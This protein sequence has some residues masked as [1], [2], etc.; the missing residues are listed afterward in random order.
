MILEA[1]FAIVSWSQK[2]YVC[3]IVGDRKTEKHNNV[4]V[5]FKRKL[6]HIDKVQALPVLSHCDPITIKMVRHFHQIKFDIQ[7][8]TVRNTMHHSIN[9]TVRLIINSNMGA[10]ISNV[11]AL[12]TSYSLSCG[13]CNIV[14]KR[15]YLTESGSRIQ[16]M[17]EEGS[18]VH[19]SLDILGPLE[20]V[21]YINARKKVKS[22]V[23]AVCC[24]F[25]GELQFECIDSMT[26]EAI[27][28]GLKLLM[29]R[30]D[31]VIRYVYTDHFS[32]FQSLAKIK[33]HLNRL[34][35]MGPENVLEFKPNKAYT[36]CRNV[37]ERYIQGAKFYLR[38]ATKN[39]YSSNQGPLT[40]FQ[41]NLLYSQIGAILNAIPFNEKSKLAPGVLS[42]SE[43]KSKDFEFPESMMKIREVD[44][45]KKYYECFKDELSNFFRSDIERVYSYLNKNSG[46]KMKPGDAIFFYKNPDDC[47]SQLL[48]GILEEVV[49][50]DVIIRLK[51]KNVT[52]SKQRV[53][54]YAPTDQ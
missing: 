39:V 2:Y 33:F 43:L 19:S 25:S 32:S 28:M 22:Y 53:Y 54:L 30:R 34:D 8:P 16:N 10:L 9:R 36:K 14:Y 50:S 6:A 3:K 40:Y 21:P 38:Q 26:N 42:R 13:I 51:N 52:L 27:I 11:R 37:I 46:I 5:G 45:I 49:G 48:F 1:W 44:R 20:V 7:T 47:N 35:G 12:V 31:I 17:K 4:L 23:I 24:L 29:N 41:T 15:L 18:F